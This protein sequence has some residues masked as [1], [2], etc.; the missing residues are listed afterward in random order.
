MYEV[1]FLSKKSDSLEII[2]FQFFQTN[3]KIYFDISRN[4]THKAQAEV[5]QFFLF[6][7]H[8]VC[9]MW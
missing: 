9:G 8:H 2:Q 1:S 4:F 3:L 7:C 6:S 5:S